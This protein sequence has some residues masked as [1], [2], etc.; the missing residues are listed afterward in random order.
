MMTKEDTRLMHT[1]A[2]LLLFAFLFSSGRFCTISSAL[3]IV[4]TPFRINLY[5]LPHI[6]KKV[7]GKTKNL[8]KLFKKRKHI[9]VICGNIKAVS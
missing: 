1:F 2:S 5:I 7:H 3:V 4:I 8:Q 6:Y 9:Y